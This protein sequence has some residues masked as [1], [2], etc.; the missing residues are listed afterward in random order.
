MTLN[1]YGNGLLGSRHETLVK[2]NKWGTGNRSAKQWSSDKGAVNI[3]SKG[4]QQVSK[5]FLINP[6]SETLGDTKFSNFW[7]NAQNP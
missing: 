2:K 5:Y 6:L 4:K 7:F 3:S 1:F